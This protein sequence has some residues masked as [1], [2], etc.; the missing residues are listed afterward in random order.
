MVDV[1]VPS[2]GTTGALAQ[3][4]RGK[5]LVVIPAL[6][7]EDS[8]A[9]IIER[10]LAAAPEIVAST[11]LRAVD[12]TVVSD[13][14]TDQTVEIAS[15]YLEWIHLIVFEKNKGYGAAI[16]EGW[17]RSDAELLGFL[18]ADGTCDPAFFV[19][20]CNTVIQDDVDVALGCRLNQESK[21]PILR[22]VGNTMFATLLSALSSSRVRDTASGM[23]V[24]RREAL[25]HLYPLPNGL[26]FTPAMSARVM[27][28]SE[29]RIAEL[30]MPYHER[31]GESKLRAG[32]DGLRFLKV[33]L[34]TALLF[35]PSRLLG[36][37]AI[38]FLLFAVLLLALPVVDWL[39]DGVWPAGVRGAQA[40]AGAVLLTAAALLIAAG[41]LAARIVE[42]V[43]RVPS[44]GRFH[45]MLQGIIGA[46]WFWVIPGIL[47]VAGIAAGLIGGLTEGGGRGLFSM[48][49]LG[50][51]AV[52]AGVTRL[53]DRFVNVVAERLRYERNVA[54]RRA[55]R[56]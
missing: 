45:R 37:T 5:L 10:C 18:D 35:R 46:R 38:P 56:A 30:D 9:S 17:R 28:S 50:A 7:E 1:E 12:V 20:L 39:N 3:D 6:N 54:A 11:G 14:S 31:E 29:L 24:V 16:K 22:R 8:I 26:H 13:G 40:A 43:L 41:Y 52:L 53:L 51:A 2:P 21:M 48:V 34:K 19:P 23:R 44:G 32:K 49:V 55:V 33:I 42:V 25:D 4:I 15:R 36:L 27:L 47:T